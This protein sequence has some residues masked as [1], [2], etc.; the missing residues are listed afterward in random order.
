MATDAGRKWGSDDKLESYVRDWLFTLFTNHMGSDLPQMDSTIPGQF[1]E[2]GQGIHIIAVDKK[3]TPR[4]IEV[5][6]GSTPGVGLM[7]HLGKRKDG[8]SQER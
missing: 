1:N 8:N 3:R 5:S 6:R 7:N 2:S 4:I